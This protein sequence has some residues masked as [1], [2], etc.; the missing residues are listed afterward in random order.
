MKVAATVPLLKGNPDQV[1]FGAGFVWVTAPEDDS[2]TRI[3]P[4]SNGGTTIDAVGN[5]PA[6]IA[7]GDGAA[8]VANGLDGTVAKIDPRAAKVVA[9]FVLGQGLSPGGVALTDGAVWV[10]VHSP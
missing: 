5:G 10:T 4:S 8:W 2:V 1:A 3:D 7:A 9:R 6:G